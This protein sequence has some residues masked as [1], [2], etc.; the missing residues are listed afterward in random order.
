MNKFLALLLTVIITPLFALAPSASAD[1]SLFTPV[2]GVFKENFVP[3][4]EAFKTT[5]KAQVHRKTTYRGSRLTYEQL[6]VV[7]PDGSYAGW[8]RG[9]DLISYVRCHKKNVCHATLPAKAGTPTEDR[10]RKVRANYGFKSLKTPLYAGSNGTT[11]YF[12]SVTPLPDSQPGKGKEG[13]RVKVSN[14]KGSSLSYT[15]SYSFF[16]GGFETR[17]SSFAVSGEPTVVTRRVATVG[18]V[19]ITNPCPNGCPNG[20]EV[21][22]AL[23]GS[24][25]GQYVTN[26]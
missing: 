6:Y 8:V 1:D 9:P 17:W 13:L 21:E 24:E 14:V 25:L 2:S 11:T 23:A 10:W 16:P 18:K 26:R 12:G 20:A 15:I 3:A 4:S 19:S 22:R 7:N 5:K